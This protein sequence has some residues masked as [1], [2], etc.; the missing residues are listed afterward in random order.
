[1]DNNTLNFFYVAKVFGSFFL[2]FWW[3]ILPT[4]FY[5]V[6]KFL[7]FDYIAGYSADSFI[8]G[9]EFTMLE[10][11]PPRE[12]ERGPKIMESFYTGIS[13]TLSNPD[14]VKIYIEGALF[15]DRFSMEL[16]SEEGKVHFYIRTE[17]KHKNLVEAQIYAQYPGAEI[18]AVKD[19]CDKLPKIV[20]NKNWDIWGA[21]FEFIKED[22]YPLKTYDKFEESITGEMIDPLTT[23]LETMGTLGPGQHVWLQFVIQPLSEKWSKE[24]AQQAVH[25]KITGRATAPTKGHWDHLMDVLFSLGPALFNKVEFGKTESKEQQPLEARLTPAE[26]DTLK[27]VEEKLGRNCFKTKMRLILIGRRETFDKAKVAAVIGAIKQFNNIH[28]NQVKPEDMT[29]T[30]ANVIHIESRSDFRK[31]KLYGRY[32]GRNMDGPTII[33]S[34]KELATIFH[35]PDMGVKSP[36]VPRV[37]SRLGSA[38]PNL[39]IE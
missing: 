8:A 31:R 21:D 32:R 37:S 9:K 35:L 13:A 12:I 18:I 39:P 3:I 20:P 29:K 10:I 17:T 1:M 25:D 22:A 36:S 19:Y 28:A 33:L 34:S 27:D 4:A 2:R 30:Y 14:N 5:Y 23:L 26:K 7:W 24:P 6:F 16:V 38:P 11:I 15:P